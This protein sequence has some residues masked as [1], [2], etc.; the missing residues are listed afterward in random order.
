MEDYHRCICRDF[1]FWVPEC[2]FADRP[3][4]GEYHCI[5]CGKPP[6][7]ETHQYIDLFP[8]ATIQIVTVTTRYC[9][10]HRPLTAKE[11]QCPPATTGSSGRS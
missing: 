3:G 5:Q 8:C 4:G 1:G 11:I 7:H 10:E 9:A 6:T 2:Y